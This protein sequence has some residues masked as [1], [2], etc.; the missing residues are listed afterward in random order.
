MVGR[1]PPSRSGL[2]DRVFPLNGG[3]GAPEGMSPPRAPKRATARPPRV[4]CTA[5]RR[6]PSEERICSVMEETKIIIRDTAVY[7]P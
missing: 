1:G 2:R 6:E 7:A 4:H 5:S 3:G